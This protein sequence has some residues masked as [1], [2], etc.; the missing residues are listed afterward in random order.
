[1]VAPQLPLIDTFL[2][3]RSR[4]GFRR[5]GAASRRSLPGVK[6]PR[7]AVAEASSG[8]GPGTAPAVPGAECRRRGRAAA[9]LA[10]GPTGHR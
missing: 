9:A 3:D 8:V 4:P 2:P 7:T 6:T 1:M 5:R 10:D